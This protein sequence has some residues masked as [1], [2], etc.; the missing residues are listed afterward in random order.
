[1]PQWIQ[2]FDVCLIP[3]KKDTISLRADPIKLY[4]YLALGKPVVSTLQF[5]EAATHVLV[6]GDPKRFAEAIKRSAADAGKGKTERIEFARHHTWRRRAGDFIAAA[7]CLL[8]RR[9]IPV[10]RKPP[11]IMPRVFVS[12]EQSRLKVLF[13]VRDDLYGEPGGDTIQIVN[14]AAALR[15]LGV[16][17]TISSDPSVQLTE[18]DGV[19]LWHLERPHETYAHLLNARTQGKPV[20][21]SPIYWPR[22]NGS[23]RAETWSSHGI[24]PLREN[25]KNALRFLNGRS[26]RERQA[27]G[28]ALKTGWGRCRKEILES[29]SMILPNS[30]AEAEA[31][32]HERG[33]RPL[34]RVVPSGINVSAC[35]LILE[36]MEPVSRDGVLCVG[37]FDPRKNQLGLIRTLRDTDIPV[38]FVGKARRMHKAYY[39]LCRRLGG[40]RM[41]FLGERGPEEVLRLM[42]RAR[43][44]VCPSLFETPGLANLEAAAMGCTLAVCDCPPVREYFGDGPI[45]FDSRNPSSMRTAILKALEAEPREDLAKRIIAK[46]TWHTAAQATL[47][48]YKEAF[49]QLKSPL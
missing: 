48:G 34:C 42:R 39:Y 31:L 16:C 13:S 17:V 23:K 11:A 37:H 14:T 32:L 6:A 15:Q 29:V 25:V 21:L 5:G 43:V 45:Y 22:R 10:P 40:R 41:Q 47:A 33:R 4:E 28:L 20:V 46:Y 12:R 30:E 8:G 24:R 7:G 9:A 44:Y 27:V 49:R 26:R 36:Q 19:H 35:R 18:F 2:A 3:F 38:V 1:M